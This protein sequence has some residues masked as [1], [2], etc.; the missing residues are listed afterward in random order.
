[1][2]RAG[3]CFEHVAVTVT[4]KRG[5]MGHRAPVSLLC[6][7]NQ[8]LMRM[9]FSAAVMPRCLNH[10]HHGPVFGHD[11]VLRLQKDSIYPAG[12]L[13]IDRHCMQASGFQIG[14]SLQGVG[15]DGFFGGQRVVEIGEDADEA[16]RQ[17]SLKAFA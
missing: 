17:A 10:A 7:P 14:Q 13:V 1:M 6:L 5:R 2:Q 4:V 12:R 3:L 8:L 11:G 16:L 15:G 9:L